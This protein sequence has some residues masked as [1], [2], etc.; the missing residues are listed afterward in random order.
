MEAKELRIGNLIKYKKGHLSKVKSLDS[1]NSLMVE[2]FEDNYINGYYDVCNFEPIPLTEEWLIK[3]G[4]KEHSKW[5]WRIPLKGNMF[6]IYDV[7]TK[8]VEIGIN[9]SRTGIAFK[10]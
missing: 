8:S 1:D 5:I 4:L 2:G 10:C 9:D 7:G 6:L 3:F